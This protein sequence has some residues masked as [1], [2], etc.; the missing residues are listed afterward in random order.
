MVKNNK[1]YWLIV[2]LFGVMLLTSCQNKAAQSGDFKITVDADGERLTYR[3]SKR[4]SVGQFL[5]EIGLVLGEND[6][7]NPLI[8][9]QVRDGMVITV[10]RV[11]ERQDGELR[12]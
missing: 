6:E 10:T 7:V 12:V 11:V 5:E 3:Y 9:T 8:Q 4:V 2:G 1:L